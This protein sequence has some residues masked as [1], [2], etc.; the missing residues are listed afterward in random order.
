M[1]L[2]KVCISSIQSQSSKGIFSGLSS[3][4]LWGLDTVLIGLVL[5]NSPL[6]D[7]GFTA[8]LI[9][10]FLHDSFSSIW[11]YIYMVLNKKSGDILSALKTRSGFFV[12][13]SSLCAGPLGMTGYVLSVFYIG[14]SYTATISSMYPAI[15]AFLAYIFFK[16]KLKPHGFFGLIMAILATV[17]LGVSSS[18]AEQEINLVMGFIFALMCTIGWGLEGVICSYGMKD[19]LKPDVA[20]QIRQ[21]TSALSYAIIIIPIFNAYP[22]T[23]KVVISP[24][25]IFLSLIALIGT[26]SYFCYYNAIDLIGPTRAM[27]LNISYSAWAVVFGIFIGSE[28]DFKL[29]LICITIIIGSILTCDNPKDI[30]YM[31]FPFIGKRRGKL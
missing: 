18:G 12:F 25:C 10:A 26:A 28:I 7:F 16:D 21:L 13:L 11:I 17:L 29:V 4:V 14:S 15:G 1:R 27:G 31:I 19:D 3:G 2:N 5:L 9:A 24:Q 20:L 6:S 22:E 23:V 8:P 30:L